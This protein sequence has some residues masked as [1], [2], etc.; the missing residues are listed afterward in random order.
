MESFIGY[1]GIGVAAVVGIVLIVWLIFFV[2]I[3]FGTKGLPQAI[4]NFFEL[5]A[6]GEIDNAYQLTTESFRAQVSK[7][8]FLKFL[9]TNK[10]KQYQRLKMAMPSIKGKDCTIGI[11]LITKSGIEIPLK[12]GLM[13]KGKDWQIDVL[14]NS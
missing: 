9:K 3:F 5:I 8:Q 10:F 1:L 11:T 6:T 7:K 2:R 13:R 14:E 12:M 4:T